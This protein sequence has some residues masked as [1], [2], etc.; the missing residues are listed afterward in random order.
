MHSHYHSIE[1]ETGPGLHLYD[2]TP[3]LC[4]AVAESGIRHGLAAVTSRHTTTALTVNEHEERLLEDIRRFFTELVP[5]DRGYL[6]NDLERRDCPPDEPRNA[7]AHIMATLLGSSESFPIVDGA[8][9]L[10]RWQSLML[11][12]LDGPARR[13]VQVQMVGE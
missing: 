6:H 12:E 8:P 13:R 5:A 3:A 2:L 4:Q 10:G 11:V 7:H 1:L 9:A